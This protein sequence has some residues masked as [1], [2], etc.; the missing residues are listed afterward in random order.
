MD[1]KASNLTARVLNLIALIIG[2]AVILNELSWLSKSKVAYV[3]TALGVAVVLNAIS[4]IIQR[5]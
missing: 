4:G 5:R 3:L 2:A 1:T